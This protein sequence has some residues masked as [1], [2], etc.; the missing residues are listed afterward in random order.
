MWRWSW[1]CRGGPVGG[2]GRGCVESKM[3]LLA[4]LWDLLTNRALHA[5]AGGH[6]LSHGVGKAGPVRIRIRGVAPYSHEGTCRPHALQSPEQL[7]G[8]EIPQGVSLLLSLLLQ[9]PHLCIYSCP[10]T[11]NVSKQHCCSSGN[12]VLR[13]AL[14][15]VLTCVSSFPL[16]LTAAPQGTCCRPHLQ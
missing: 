14:T 16:I 15:T 1:W 2:E 6:T 12:A 5:G 8:A 13:A 10:F 3:C 7:P 9:F 11:V 4:G